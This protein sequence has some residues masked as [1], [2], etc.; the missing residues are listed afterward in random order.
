MGLNI[1]LTG[2]RRVRLAPLVAL[3]SVLALA[4]CGD[5]GSWFSGTWLTGM[6]DSGVSHTGAML[7][8][9]CHSVVPGCGGA[10]ADLPPIP[11]G[12]AGAYHLGPGD[13]VRIITL[14]EDRLTG[15]FRVNDSGAV[16]LPLLGTVRAAGLTTAELG[17]AIS[18]ALVDGQ[19]IRSPSVAVEVIA[20][21]PIFVLGEVNKP[22]QYPYQPGMTVVTAVAVAGGFTYRAVD[23]RASIVR[24]IDGKAG[25]GRATRE[26]YV[27]PGDV[28][29]IYERRF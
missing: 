16:A 2:A 6:W 24:S 18:A 28:I 15:E 20:Y 9:A 3:I 13:Q 10:G 19:L 14:G 26:T 27:Q 25:E 1:C 4:G 23:D 29:T 21:R 7:T 11:E 22:G 5:S 12:A 8:G 17:A